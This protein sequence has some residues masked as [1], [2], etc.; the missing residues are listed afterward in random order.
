[1]ILALGL[2]ALACRPALADEEEGGQTYEYFGLHIKGCVPDQLADCQKSP[3][4]PEC[5]KAA[6][7]TQED[8]QNALER[9]D[10]KIEDTVKWKKEHGE[11]TEPMVKRMEQH[12]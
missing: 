7:K 11:A 2:A 10:D 8:C 3:Y 4:T 12:T 9:R 1:A 6:G 5:Y